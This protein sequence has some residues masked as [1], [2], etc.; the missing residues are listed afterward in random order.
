ML[1]GLSMQIAGEATLQPQQQQLGQARAEAA[2][3]SSCTEAGRCLTHP[4]CRVW[5]YTISAT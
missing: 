3:G 4:S 1:T 2:V 5:T